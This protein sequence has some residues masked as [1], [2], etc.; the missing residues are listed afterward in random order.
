M[1]PLAGIC[2]RR[3]AVALI[4]AASASP[5][6][7][8]NEGRYPDRLIRI[9]VPLPAG[10]GV[11]ALSRLVA[12]RIAGA[13]GQSV[14]VEN[15]PGAT[16]GIGASAVTQ[17]KPDGYTLLIAI[18][19]TIQ[20]ISLQKKPLFPALRACPDRATR[21]PA[22]R[23]RRAGQPRRR[24]AC[25]LRE[26]CCQQARRPDL[27]LGRDRLDRAYSWRGPGLRRRHQDRAC[28]LQGRGADDQRSAGRPDLL[29]LRLGRRLGTASGRGRPVA[30]PAHRL[31]RFPDVPTFEELGYPM[32]GLNGWAG[33]FAPAGISTAITDKLA[34]ELDRVVRTPEMQAR[35]RD[36]GFEP[37]GA[38]R[39]RSLLSSA[40]RPRDG[41]RRRSRWASSRM[42]GHAG[43]AACLPSRSR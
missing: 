24:L 20:A 21:G 34:G 13:W 38:R 27:R 32:Q 5:A 23:V 37:L 36:F 1:R 43:R 12:E 18:A 17:A 16:G 11:D 25:R 22:D 8:Q 7:A 6:W 9:V 14:I 41:Q 28:A 3:R 31:S 4:A 2:G 33:A 15:K 40:A 26:A 35:I 42:S 29:G 39:C 30:S 10:G 19:S